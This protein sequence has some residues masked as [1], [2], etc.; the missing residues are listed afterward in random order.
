MLNNLIKGDIHSS[1]AARE[2]YSKDAS[3]FKVYPIAVAVPKDVDDISKIIDHVTTINKSGGDLTIAARNGGT[4]MSGGSLTEGIVLDMSR[5]M[6]R[7]GEVDLFNKTITVQ[8]GVMHRDI[9]AEAS[10]HKLI[11]A[12]YTSSKD[13]CGIGGMIG[14]NASGELSLI[15]GP[16]SKNINSLKAILSDGK[17][18]LFAPLS[19]KELKNKLDQMD[20]EG[21]I[22]RKVIRLLKDNKHLIATHH[23]NV[24]K[25][26]AGYPL[27][28]LWDKQEQIFNLGRIF[29]GSQGTLGI[30]SEATLKLVDRAPYQQ[31]IVCA[32]DKLSQLTGVVNSLV[33]HGASICETFDHHT[34]QLAKEKYQHEAEF[35]NFANGKHMIVYA[36]FDGDSMKS[37]EITAGEAK[38][39]IEKDLNIEVSWIDNPEVKSSFQAIR[40]Y[41]FKMLM[42]MNSISQKAMPFIEDS[43]VPLEHYGQFVSALEAILE[44]YDMIYTYAGHIGQG[45]IRLIPLVNIS[46]KT[47]DEI[48]DLESRVNE[49]VLA[50]RGSISVDHNDGIIRTPYLSQQYGEE[51]VALFN[52]IKNIF[53]PYNVFNKGKKVHA[54]IDFAREHI[55]I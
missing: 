41:S 43:I 30:V 52:Q 17:E 1:S 6:T 14:N 2:A 13:I 12:P 46:S 37:A 16:T 22:Y 55:D 33:N 44:D 9:E 29:V 18:Y 34:Y 15:Y 49:L 4:C 28:E 50:F 35:A 47:A 32:I 20:F 54:T 38:N 7:I 48:I 53:D 23:P 45:S 26:A 36:I 3:I 21:D 19:R 24:S 11:F 8:T 27:W 31:M 39:N 42:D 10:K 25:N 40:R 51:M 5:Y